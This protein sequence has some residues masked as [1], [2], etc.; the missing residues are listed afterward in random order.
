M[1]TITINDI[2]NSRSMKPARAKAIISLVV[3]EA[4][5]PVTT[6]YKYIMNSNSI[7]FGAATTY[8]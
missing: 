8:Q 6:S 4:Y 2:H 7:R 5:R 3:N 1:Y